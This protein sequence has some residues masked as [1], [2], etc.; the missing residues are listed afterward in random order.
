ML[1][2]LKLVIEVFSPGVEKRL[3]WFFES[4]NFGV[5]N[6]ILRAKLAD[7]LYLALEK[8][9]CRFFESKHH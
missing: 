9:S 1:S 2:G 8:R 7:Q 4:K 3:C 5:C 6:A